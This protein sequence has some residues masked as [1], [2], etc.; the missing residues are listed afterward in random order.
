M[1]ADF[2]EAD[3]YIKG[4]VNDVMMEYFSVLHELQPA[5]EIEILLDH[6][7]GGLRHH[8]HPCAGKIKVLKPEDRAADRGNKYEDNGT[9]DLRLIIDGAKWDDYEERQR[10]AL[11][12]H[13]LHHI[14]PVFNKKANSYKR[15]LFGRVKL[16]LRKDD[17]MLTGFLAAVEVFGEDALEYQALQAVLKVIKSNRTLFSSASASSVSTKPKKKKKATSKVAAVSAVSD[18][19][20]SAESADD[21][22][23]QTQVA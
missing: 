21:E 20:D 1:A 11:V 10:T 18:D 16:K 15:D 23:P 8:G 14:V 13:E 7:E 17:W 22:S 6:S 12:W 5:I 19:P 9:P 2:K 3:D 4:F